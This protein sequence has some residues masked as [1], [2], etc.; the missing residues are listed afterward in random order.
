M[1]ATLSACLPA[2]ILHLGIQAAMKGRA[3]DG[4]ASNK[5]RSEKKEV[6]EGARTPPNAGDIL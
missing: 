2:A 1:N 3:K 5:Q 4:A 6:G